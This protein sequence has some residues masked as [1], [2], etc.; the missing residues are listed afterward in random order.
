MDTV[1]KMASN[2]F[3]ERKKPESIKRGEKLGMLLCQKTQ[4]DAFMKLST[5]NNWGLA[6]Q[7]PLEVGACSAGTASGS[8]SRPLALP[9]P[10][11]LN[12]HF[13]PLFVFVFSRFLLFLASTFPQQ[14]CFLCSSGSFPPL[15]FLPPT[16]CH[17][18]KLR[19]PTPLEATF[20]IAASL[21]SW[22]PCEAGAAS[23]CPPLPRLPRPEAPALGPPCPLWEASDCA[24]SSHQRAASRQRGPL[25]SASVFTRPSGSQDAARPPCWCPRQR[26]NSIFPDWPQTVWQLATHSAH[27]GRH[28]GL[29][30]HAA[31]LF[32]NPASCAHLRFIRSVSLFHKTKGLTRVT[33]TS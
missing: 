29:D 21:F 12:K 20:W 2:I 30:L 18:G 31:V 1:C 3:R 33:C 19:T 22:H 7:A 5:G 6:A 17:L 16:T 28:S 4:L 23:G 14:H 32:P 24:A 10:A 15:L 8:G 13:H 27:T 25:A 26:R 11:Y 9:P